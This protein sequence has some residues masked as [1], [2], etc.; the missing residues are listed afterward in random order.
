MCARLLIVNADDFGLSPGVNRGIIRAHR[1][2][3]VTSATLMINMGAVAEAVALARQTPTLPVG[4]HLTLTAGRPLAPDVPSLVGPDGRFLKGQALASSARTRD[5]EREVRAQVEG[6]LATGLPLSHIDSHHHVHMELPRL[7]K[8]VTGVAAELGV[9]VR[10]EAC[11]FT[12]AFYA[13]DHIS[14]G[15][16]LA[17]L[18]QLPEGLSEMMCHPAEL[19]PQL[20]HLSS[21]CAER[22]TELITLTSP[23]I[24]RA[25]E[26]EQ[27]QLTTYAEGRVISE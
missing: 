9:P 23:W 2:G 1:E 8:I 25:L 4:L 22:V 5:L 14:P 12:A 7:R 21:Y 6:F 16:L 17:I 15:G 10:D 19:D 18:H 11:H 20:P 26:A 3:I 13:R 24:R 27:I